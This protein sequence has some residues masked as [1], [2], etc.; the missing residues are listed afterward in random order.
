MACGG[1]EEVVKIVDIE[2]KMEKALL[3][4]HKGSIV[5]II[6]ADSHLL[7]GSSDGDISIWKLVSHDWTMVRTLSTAK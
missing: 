1:A 3:V 4:H 5:K 2:S 6:E 7:V